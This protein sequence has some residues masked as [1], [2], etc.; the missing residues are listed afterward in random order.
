MPDPAYPEAFLKWA[1]D[2]AR[3][4]DQLCALELFI[5]HGRE[6]WGEVHGEPVGFDFDGPQARARRRRDNPAY[7]P[8][9]DRRLVEQTAEVWEDITVWRDGIHEDRPL[10][11]LAMLRFFPRLQELSLAA[12]ETGDLSPLSGLRELRVLS[13]RESGEKPRH[14]LQGISALA[15]LRGLQQ[16]SLT[17]RTPWPDVSALATLPRLMTLSLTM[18]ALALVG[19][20]PLPSVCGLTLMPVLSATTPL[21][22]LEDL[23]DMPALQYLTLAHVAD[24]RGAARFPHL[25]TLSLT[26][27]FPDLAPLAALR[28]LISLRLEGDQYEDLQP[29]AGL[30]QLREVELERSYPLDVSPL[31]ESMSL[32]ELRMVGCPMLATEVAAVNAALLSWDADFAAPTPRPLEP[33]RFFHFD[34]AHDDVLRLRAGPKPPGPREQEAHWDSVLARAEGRWFAASLQQRLDA[35]LG[36]GWGEVRSGG[37]VSGFERF[38]IDRTR[39]I[40]QCREII[41]TARALIASCRYPW[42]VSVVFEPE[43]DF[44]GLVEEWLDSADPDRSWKEEGE[45]DEEDDADPDR[46]DDIHEYYRKLRMEARE[47][48]EREYRLH[49]LEQQGLPVNPADFEPPPEPEAE[50]SEFPVSVEPYDEEED[51]SF[52]IYIREETVWLPK[53]QRHAA[54]RFIDIPMEDWHALPEPPEDRPL[55]P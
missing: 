17:L 38:Q 35:L 7:R 3:T 4:N 45:K 2:P 48:Q 22:S 11:D 21:R 25:H 24:L 32:R 53:Q 37:A 5:E 9:L 18:N 1:L 33:A 47:R 26:G 20:P 42:M 44:G 14:L 50:S 13:L 36:A 6:V 28:E 40:M 51:P 23:P 43:D 12:L 39:D 15:G 31:V 30:P 27:P 52:T 46:Y 41:E 34:I 29:L 54:E 10:R 19:L 55:P 49:L 16:L 8:V